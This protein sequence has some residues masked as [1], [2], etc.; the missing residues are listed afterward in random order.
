MKMTFRLLIAVIIT[1]VIINPSCRPTDYSSDINAL[2]LRCDSLANELEITNANL[3]ATNNTLASLSS[4]IISI[5]AQLAVISGQIST[6]DAQVAATDAIV[7][8]HT[9]AIDS[10]QAA[11]N[12]IRNQFVVLNTHQIE[13]SSTVNI[14]STTITAIQTQITFILN[15]VD[16]LNSQQTVTRDYLSDISDRLTLSNNQLISLSLQFNGLLTQLGLVVD[17]EGNIYH[18]VIIGKQVWMVEN[19]KSTKFRNGD[20]IPY[21]SGANE[22]G[23][24]WYGDDDKNKSDY[25]AIYTYN[26]VIDPRNICPLGWHV[27]T[28]PEWTTLSNSLGGASVSGGKLKEPGTVHWISPNTGATNALGFNA[29]PGGLR[30]CSGSFISM[31]TKAHF[32]VSS[33]VVKDSVNVISIFNSNTQLAVERILDCNLVSVRCIKDRTN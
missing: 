9:S 8:D 2:K 13:T 23:Y 10:I 22:T 5:Q 16:T 25:G 26:T 3:Q 15:Q 27:P 31:G 19:L 28:L 33:P 32:F 20:Q 12:M 24:C 18:T 21:S 11:I 6:L 7:T 30:D 1:S 17:V 4:T 14:L 29:L